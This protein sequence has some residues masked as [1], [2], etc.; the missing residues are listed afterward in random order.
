MLSGGGG[1][2]LLRGCSQPRKLTFYCIFGPLFSDC[3]VVVNSKFLRKKSIFWT[4]NQVFGQKFEFFSKIMSSLQ[5]RGRKLIKTVTLTRI[6]AKNVIF[7]QKSHFL[8]QKRQFFP[9]FSAPSAPKMRGCSQF[10]RRFWGFR[11]PPLRRGPPR[12][13][14]W[15]HRY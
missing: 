11:P 1:L 7:V 5:P 9:K 3:A 13:H 15:F 6:F 10:F 2:G 8:G 4:K 14:L 12:Q